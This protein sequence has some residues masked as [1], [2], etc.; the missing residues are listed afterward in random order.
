MSKG[1]RRR[2]IAARDGAD[3]WKALVLAFVLLVS[4]AGGGI[5]EEPPRSSLEALRQRMIHGETATVEGRIYMERRRPNDPDEP[6]VGVGVLIVPHSAAL[7]AALEAAKERSRES[8]DGFRE[9]APTTRA[10][11]RAYETDLW[12]LGYPDAAIHAVTDS[13]G[14]FRATVPRGRWMVFA[15]R[16]VFVSIS[17]RDKPAAADLLAR[18]SMSQYQHFQKIARVVGYDAVSVWLREVELAAGTTATVDLHDRGLWLSGVIEETE[19]PVRVRSRT[20]SGS[21]R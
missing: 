6:L 17:D 18:S 19:V 20:S 8:A 15:E 4:A 9:A 1:I 13:Q 11:V 2:G 21:R 7:L 5:A 16:S 10:S 3:R 14:R 12:R